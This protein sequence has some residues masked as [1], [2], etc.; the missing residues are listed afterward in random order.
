[1][2]EINK[3]QFSHMEAWVSIGQWKL[4]ISNCVYLKKLQSFLNVVYHL[5]H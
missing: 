2:L 4:K 3:L 1:M 5:V